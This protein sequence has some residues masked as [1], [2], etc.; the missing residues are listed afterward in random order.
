MHTSWIARG[1]GKRHKQGSQRGGGANHPARCSLWCH[2]WYAELRKRYMQSGGSSRCSA[3]QCRAVQCV[4][5]AG[6]S[7]GGKR[8]SRIYIAQPLSDRPRKSLYL[9]QAEMWSPIFSDQPADWQ[10]AAPSIFFSFPSFF[11]AFSGRRKLSELWRSC[12][13][14]RQGASHG[15]KDEKKVHL[16]QLVVRPSLMPH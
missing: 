5:S 13:F 15:S 14:I 8:F 16:V 4:L 1:F 12:S 2:H 7:A 9:M 11:S 6:D 10:T 3:E